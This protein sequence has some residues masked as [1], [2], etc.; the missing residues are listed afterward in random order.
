MKRTSRRHLGLGATEPASPSSVG[1]VVLAEVWRVGLS[2]GGEEGP[3]CHSLVLD[4]PTGDGMGP[5]CVRKRRESSD[6]S[7]ALSQLLRPHSGCRI[8]GTLKASPG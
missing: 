8:Q 1:S 5:E 3:L 2:R 6:A 4:G 7:L